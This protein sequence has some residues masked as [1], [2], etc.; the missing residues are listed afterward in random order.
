MAWGAAKRAADKAK[1]KA[2][3][4]HAQSDA[5]GYYEIQDTGRPVEFVRPLRGPFVRVQDMRDKTKTNVHFEDLKPLNEMA[6][7][8]YMT[9][10]E[11]D[12]LRAT[13]PETVESPGRDAEP[14][15]PGDEGF[16]R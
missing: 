9:W 10:T 16:L 5:G 2:F 15:E 6:V 4:E 11:T 3:L 1:L 7:L 14:Q 8:G 13:G 12:E